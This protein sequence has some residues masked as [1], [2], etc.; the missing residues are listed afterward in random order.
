MHNVHILVP[1]LSFFQ[2]SSFFHGILFYKIFIYNF[3]FLYKKGNPSKM[4]A[5]DRKSPECKRL[6]IYI[7]GSIV[8]LFCIP[9][10]IFHT[11]PL[12]KFRANLNLYFGLTVFLF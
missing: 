1:F 10:D 4:L 7:P 6:S 11:S 5:K 8:L 2:I 3:T 9:T 12:D